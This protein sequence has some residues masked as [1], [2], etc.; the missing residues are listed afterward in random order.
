MDT[1]TKI[2]QDYYDG[3]VETEW[4]RIANRPEFLLTCRMLNRYIK[5]GDKVLDIGG[6]PGRYSLYLAGRGC[7][8]T[9]FD[10]SQENTKF[11]AAEASRQG[12]SIKTITG[13]ARAAD[14]LAIELYDHVLLMGPMYH[15]L[16]EVDRVRAMQAA[17]NVLKPG[18]VIFVS[19]INLFAGVVYMMKY[20]QAVINSDE[21]YE[22]EYNDCVQNKKSYAGDAFTKA[23]FAAQSEILPFMAQFPLTKL[24]LFG[25]EGILSPCEHSIMTQ[26]Q[27]VVDG[28]LDFAEK[29]LD[30]EDLLSWAE[31]LMYVGKKL[32]ANENIE[33]DVQKEIEYYNSLPCVFDGFI[34]V[35]TLSD[36]MVYL[37][38]LDK[39]PGDP[40]KKH[41]PGYE[42]AI[43]VGGEKVGRINLRIGYGG[44]PYNCNLYYDG[45]IGYSVNEVH[46]GNGYAVRACRLLIPVAK[47]HN[48]TKILITNNETNIA[49]R[50][51]CEKLG[52]R[53][54]RKVQLPE[55]SELYKEGQRF[56]NIFVMDIE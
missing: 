51:V 39:Q 1:T 24:H 56:V 47:A 46:R 13:D 41:V 3:C 17:V 25:Q 7:D 55:W 54:V 33:A 29:L 53:H 15:L 35:P 30:R 32:E 14:N 37:V 18:G 12:L 43:C 26:S 6:G 36:E 40:N 16:E 21:P 28:W 11:G 38:C 10:L 48:M 49:S 8:V 44:G 42:F 19:F 23:F 31:H 2:V 4:N 34:D 50:R 52:A 27:E 9:L 20:D 45:Q 22:L 5:A